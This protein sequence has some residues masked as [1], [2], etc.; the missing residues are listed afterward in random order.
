MSNKE[1]WLWSYIISQVFLIILVALYFSCYFFPAI[2]DAVIRMFGGNGI[3][4]IETFVTI[5][6]WNIIIEPPVF[7]GMIF[8]LETLAPYTEDE[9]SEDTE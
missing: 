5:L 2:Q 7:R 4:P 1:K 3:C 9:E 6:I 8:V